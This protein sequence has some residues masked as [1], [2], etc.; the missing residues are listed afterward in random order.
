MCINAFLWK[1]WF[2]NMYSIMRRQLF[3]FLLHSTKSL[4][5]FC[6]KYFCIHLGCD[7]EA[8]VSTFEKTIG[9]ELLYLSAAAAVTKKVKLWIGLGT[10][11]WLLL[12]TVV[13]K[14]FLQVYLLNTKPFYWSCSCK[15]REL[16][17][18]R[19]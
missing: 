3:Y 17:V 18:L 11:Q 16:R 19:I 15:E 10:S 8:I 5:V 13:I 12:S 9:V 14:C 2:V 1:K 4:S 6:F 7:I